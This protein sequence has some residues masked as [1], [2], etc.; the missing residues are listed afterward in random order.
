MQPVTCALSCRRLHTWWYTYS[1]LS[2]LYLCEWWEAI[3]HQLAIGAVLLV[4]VFSLWRA[5]R[6][7]LYVFDYL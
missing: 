1:V 5:V 3:I 4:A 6:M 7:V 2:G